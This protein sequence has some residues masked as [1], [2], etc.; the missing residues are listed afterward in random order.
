MHFDVMKTEGGLEREAGVRGSLRRLKGTLNPLVAAQGTQLFT[1]SII[2]LR[3]H[4]FAFPFYCMLILLCIFI[5]HF[6][7][8]MQ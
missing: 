2:S 6:S 1:A 3:L 4:P 7:L 5:L 8:C